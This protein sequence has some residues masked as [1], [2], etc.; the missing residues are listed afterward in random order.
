[1]TPAGR[2]CTMY[3]MLLRLWMLLVLAAYPALVGWMQ[4]PM[5]LTSPA[6]GVAEQMQMCCASAPHAGRGCC[7]SEPA[8]PV[9][10]CEEVASEG[11][12]PCRAMECCPIRRFC[13]GPCRSMPGSPLGPPSRQEA[14]NKPD[15]S[16]VGM[17]SY[18]LAEGA[19]PRRTPDAAF[20]MPRSVPV[21]A[22]HAT[23]CIRTI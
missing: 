15:Q 6:L 11:D 8:E 17:P 7:A 20:V 12:S 18:P 3:T 4:T 23:L 13:P 10:C 16:P 1:M 5:C 14:Q 22:R 21:S 2:Y 9:G 19:L